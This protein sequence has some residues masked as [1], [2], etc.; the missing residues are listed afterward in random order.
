M[1]CT[2]SRKQHRRT[3][4]TFPNS[5]TLPDDIYTV[6]LEQ[7]NDYAASNALLE[8]IAQN[9]DLNGIVEGNILVIKQDRRNPLNII[10][11]HEKDVFLTN[12]LIRRQVSRYTV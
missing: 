4:D 1:T 8:D 2:A 7:V 10:D 12:F 3:F 11:M 5:S 9:T 6:F